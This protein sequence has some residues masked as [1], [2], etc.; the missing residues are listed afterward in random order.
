MPLGILGCGTAHSIALGNVATDEG[1]AAP[2]GAMML[3]PR[4]E[5]NAPNIVRAK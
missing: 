3:Q 1:R 5:T 4:A 2:Q